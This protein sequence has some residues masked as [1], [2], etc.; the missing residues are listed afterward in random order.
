L[1]ARARRDCNGYKL[2]AILVQTIQQ[3]AARRAKIPIAQHQPA[4]GRRSL[5]RWPFWKTVPRF[6]RESTTRDLV[7]SFRA[8]RCGT[9]GATGLEH[10]F[11][12]ACA[13]KPLHSGRESLY[14]ILQALGL[15]R[16]SRVGVPLYCCDAVFMAIAAAGH[17]PVFLDIDLNTY[18]LAEE[19]VWRNRHGLDALIVVHT[20]GY[21]VNLGRIQDALGERD[22]PVIE[23][24]AHSLFSEYMGMPTGSWTQ[25]SFFTFGPHKPAAT[26]GGGLLVVNNP[27]IASRLEMTCRFLEHPRKTEELKQL[28][29]TWVR[30]LCYARPA[31]GALL[32]MSS[33]SPRDGRVDEA[34]HRAFIDGLS[35]IK[36]GTMRRVDRAPLAARVR[37][38]R[39]SL[40]ALERHTSEIRAAVCETPLKMPSEPDFG[41]WNHFMIPVR[42][43]S[44]TQRD[45]GRRFLRRHGID[46]SPLYRN[47][48]R[49]A[50]LYGYRGG[51]K[52][53][54]L[55]ARTV[56]TVPNHAWL[57]AEETQHICDALR[58]CC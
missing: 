28:L 21:P 31:Y 55:A 13:V 36:S 15:R 42:F 48:M 7:A 24:C 40:S 41:T 30:G 20:F 8:L 26:G 53:G 25:A 17:F 46:T 12:T 54:E 35:R 14:M 2:L 37:R 1:D 11:G 47:C 49:N 58:L 32:A 44:E 33:H 27:A 34:Q 56:C 3:K 10:Y 16:G 38:F 9:V 39:D 43:P 18:G 5:A 19:S 22:I 23:D 6:D 45:A 52:N 51:C 4:D 29:G 57:T 50:A